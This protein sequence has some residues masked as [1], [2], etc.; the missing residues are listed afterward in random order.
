LISI[1]SAFHDPDLSV[2]LDTILEMSSFEARSTPRTSIV[3]TSK[4]L[5]AD[6][7]SYPK[8]PIAVKQMNKQKLRNRGR[9]KLPKRLGP[10]D[11]LRFPP[12]GRLLFTFRGALLPTAF[13]LAC[14]AIFNFR[15]RVF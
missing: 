5:D 9:K 4:K 10:C 11:E 8:N 14:D 15:A 1:R 2:E 13:F 12:A 6:T 7:L 3:L